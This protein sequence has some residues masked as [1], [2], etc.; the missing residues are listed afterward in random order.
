VMARVRS[1][2]Q[3]AQDRLQRSVMR[4]TTITGAPLRG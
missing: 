1:N 2:A 3:N 4:Q